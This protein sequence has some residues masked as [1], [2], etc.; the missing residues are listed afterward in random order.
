MKQES[1]LTRIN[2][3]LHKLSIT[4]TDER[5]LNTYPE[6]V[7]VTLVGDGVWLCEYVLQDLKLKLCR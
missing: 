2:C 5:A 1:Q 7:D 4:C 6:I 3:K